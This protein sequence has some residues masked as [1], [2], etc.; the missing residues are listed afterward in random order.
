MSMI[1]PD[2]LHTW[3]KEFG[4]GVGVRLAPRS[5]AACWPQHPE[6]VHELTGLYLA[7]TALNDAF[8]PPDDDDGLAAYTVPAPRDWLD[9]S[10]ASVPAVDRATKS[11]TTCARAGHH[12]GGTTND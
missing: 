6:A 5:L 10:N 11:T 1:N 4:P 7:W 3:I 9:L 8:T 12:I 2:H